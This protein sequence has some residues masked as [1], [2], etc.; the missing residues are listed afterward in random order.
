[1]YVNSYDSKTRKLFKIFKQ[2]SKYIKIN[3]C[4][5]IFDII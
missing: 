3:F 2:R 4:Y 5:N 1:M